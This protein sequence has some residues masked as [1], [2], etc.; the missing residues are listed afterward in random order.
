MNHYLEA[1]HPIHC[2]TFILAVIT[3]IK[4]T[5]KNKSFQILPPPLYDSN[6]SL[7]SEFLLTSP[8]LALST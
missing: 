2:I 1:I 6:K 3:P 5:N 4:N 8:C 7:K